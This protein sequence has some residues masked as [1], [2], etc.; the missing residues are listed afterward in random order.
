MNQIELAG[1]SAGFI[2]TLFFFPIDTIKS[3]F[4]AN[5]YHTSHLFKGITPEMT[6]NTISSFAYWSIY[7]YSRN[8]YNPVIS[9]VISCTLSNIIDSPLDYI[10]KQKQL[11]IQYKFNN[12]FTKQFMLYSFLNTTYSVVYNVSYMNML[13]STPVEKRNKL[14]TLCTAS[15]I[16]AIIS[17]PI[18]YYRTII[19][20]NN[21][22]NNC[23]NKIQFNSNTFFKGLSIR[24]LY[25]NLYS[26]FYMYI[27]LSITGNQL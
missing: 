22:N 27:L 17:Y 23:S 7:K 25:A 12:F 3:R 19:V 11:G 20:F 13:S 4:Q 24:L 16:S 2:S 9:S 1:T 8:Y 26:P 21:K 6:S 10:K 14:I 18:D 15:T 5:Q